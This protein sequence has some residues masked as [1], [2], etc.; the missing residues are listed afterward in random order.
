MQKWTKDKITK[1]NHQKDSYEARW[2]F[3]QTKK[4]YA[5][6]SASY[7]FQAWVFNLFDLGAS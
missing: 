4:Y 1:A 3:A 6:V 5:C 2:E 7:Y